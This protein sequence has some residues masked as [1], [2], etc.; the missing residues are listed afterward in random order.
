LPRTPTSSARRGRPPAASPEALSRERI[1]A[2]ALEELDA[3][4]LAAF[5]IR[6][7][8][9]RLGVYPAAIYWHV[10]TR[11]QLLAAMVAAVLAEVA[12]PRRPGEC[13]KDWLAELFRRTRA[14]IRR[15]PGIAP[16]VGA[17]MVSNAGVDFVMIERLLEV[18]GEAGFAGAG[19]VEAFSTVVA[20]E[21]GFV[22]MEFAPL[23]A[24]GAAAWTESMRAMIDSVDPQR[25]PRLAANL[26]AM[27]NRSFMLRWQNGIEAP[28][29][30]P[31][32]AYVATVIAGLEALGAGCPPGSRLA[33]GSG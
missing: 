1:V 30:G 27:A 11:N 5:S 22:T 9:R 31:F 18:L 32:E 2:A 21:V 15:H 23:P 6:E 20:A 7:V 8:A 3:F 10:S 25:Y 19:L 13:W 14:A 26:P 28:M 12:P 33:L 17:Q 16:L 4:G 24:E 29:D